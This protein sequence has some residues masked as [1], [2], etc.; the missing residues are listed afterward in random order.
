[1][2]NMAFFTSQLTSKEVLSDHCVQHSVL[3]SINSPSQPL[4]H[5]TTSCGLPADLE[6]TP[7]KTLISCTNRFKKRWGHAALKPTFPSISAVL[8][9]PMVALSFNFPPGFQCTVSKFV[10]MQALANTIKLV[11][12]SDS[13][14][15]DAISLQVLRTF[16]SLF[17]RFY[18]HREKLTTV[19][20]LGCEFV[21]FCR[22]FFPS[23]TLQ[24]LHVR[25]YQFRA[26]SALVDGKRKKKGKKYIHSL[27]AMHIYS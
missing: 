5:L 12:Q 16:C 23:L 2:Q 14:G 20:I 17:A 7:H 15:Q 3:F 11:T 4:I 1:M 13:V 21:L 22:C 8:K 24:L 25:V 26:N 9:A 27:A 6:D 18:Q 19:F 10:F